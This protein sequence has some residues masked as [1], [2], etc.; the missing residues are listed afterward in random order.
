MIK[1]I[2]NLYDIINKN[3]KLERARPIVWRNDTWHR[4]SINYISR[5]G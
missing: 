3:R 2:I 5:Y 1:A 4:Y